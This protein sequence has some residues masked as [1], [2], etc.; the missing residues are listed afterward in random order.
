MPFDGLVQSVNFK[1]GEYL[2]LGMTAVS[3]ISNDFL[4]KADI[5]ETDIAKI[6]TGQ[7]VDISL[8]AFSDEKIKGTI[9]EISPISKNTAGVISFQLTIKPL[10]AKPGILMFGLSANTTIYTSKVE[11]VLTIPYLAIFEENNKSYVWILNDKKETVKVE[12]KTGLSDLENIEIKSGLK[13]GDIVL[14]SK[15]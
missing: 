6:K 7:D 1:E 12:V 5:E 14:I 10:D 3:V 13:E 9:I 15:P 11:N 2:S 4:I 8:D